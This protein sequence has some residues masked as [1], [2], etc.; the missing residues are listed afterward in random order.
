MG[1]LDWRNTTLSLNRDRREVTVSAVSFSEWRVPV[2]HFLLSPHKLPPSA[3]HP[4]PSAHSFL[5]QISYAYPR[6]RQRTCDSSRIASFHERQG[7][8]IL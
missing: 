1:R 3:P 2:A 7:P 5:H 8:R 6:G 4:S